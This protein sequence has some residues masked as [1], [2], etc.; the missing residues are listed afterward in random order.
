MIYNY[1]SDDGELVLWMGPGLDDGST[2]TGAGMVTI[3]AGTVAVAVPE[4]LD[5]VADAEP[6]S[7]SPP[8]EETVDPSKAESLLF[9]RWDNF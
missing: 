6:S 7:D 2:L 4:L 3:L 1:L 9:S 8:I 5:R